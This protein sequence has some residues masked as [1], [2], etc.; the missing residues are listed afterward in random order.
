M[1]ILIIIITIII[2]YSIFY[3]IFNEKYNNICMGEPEVYIYDSMIKGPNIMIIGA[4]HGNEPSGYVAIKNL[5]DLLNNKTI[6]LKIGKLYLIPVVNYCGL[7]LNTRNG[8]SINIM[9]DINRN[10][11]EDTKY[12]INKTVLEFA[13][14]SDFILDFHEGWG[15]HTNS[16][17]IGSTI[18]PYNNSMKIAQSMM[19][20][21]NND[22]TDPIKKFAI[23][24]NDIELLKDNNYIINTEIKG[25]LSN[26]IT[27]INKNNINYIL[28]EITGQSNDISINLRLAQAMIFIDTLLD[29]YIMK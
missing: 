19:N 10:Y 4:T 5:M 14:K 18:T 9:N 12:P 15:Y 3:L 25:T 29:N 22:I 13:T 27:N 26:Y 20:N 7:K 28:I 23:R 17:S 21:I 1:I 8:S 2:V 6:K 16:N 24:T 11:F